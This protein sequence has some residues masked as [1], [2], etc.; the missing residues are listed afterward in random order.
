[1][2]TRSSN[3]QNPQT[4]IK[5]LASLLNICLSPFHTESGLMTVREDSVATSVYRTALSGEGC[6][7]ATR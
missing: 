3:V 6:D 5:I 7:D 4:A 2:L 1:M